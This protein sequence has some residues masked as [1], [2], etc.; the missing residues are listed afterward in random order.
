MLIDIKLFYYCLQTSREMACVV[1]L[2]VVGWL[3]RCGWSTLCIL[4]FYLF[5]E[6]SQFS[7]MGYVK[8]NFV[9]CHMCSFLL[10]LLLLNRLHSS[11]CILYFTLNMSYVKHFIPIF[12]RADSLKSWEF[13]CAQ[14]F[15]WYR[16]IGLITNCGNTL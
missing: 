3:G 13:S 4:M 15:T 7:N 9:C 16:K 1:L 6:F 11:I 8:Q 5:L 12:C 10:L 2:I 14:F